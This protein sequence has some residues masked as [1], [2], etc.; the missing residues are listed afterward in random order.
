MDK[1]CEIKQKQLDSIY[2][3]LSVQQK[4]LYQLFA[5]IIKTEKRKLSR[6]EYRM[7]IE[8]PACSM[9]V[10]RALNIF[11]LLEVTLQEN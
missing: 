6:E 4:I 11:S 5:D 10:E 2:V 7:L 9:K 3:N 8:D 1:F